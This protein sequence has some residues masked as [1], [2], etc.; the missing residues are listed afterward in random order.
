M[1]SHHGRRES[2]DKKSHG[3]KGSSKTPSGFYQTGD[4]STSKGKHRSNY[5]EEE[6]PASLDSHAAFAHSTSYPGAPADSQSYQQ[7]ADYPDIGQLSL[8][9]QQY[10]YAAVKNQVQ[11]HSSDPLNGVS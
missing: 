9:Q 7:N 11:S 3:D 5:G 6:G 4:E 10:P 8:G 2:K 1:S